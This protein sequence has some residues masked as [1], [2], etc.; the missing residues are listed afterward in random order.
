MEPRFADVE[1][2][3]KSHTKI[4]PQGKRDTE[5]FRQDLLDGRDGGKKREAGSFPA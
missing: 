1:K 3:S 4:S 2:G 5:S